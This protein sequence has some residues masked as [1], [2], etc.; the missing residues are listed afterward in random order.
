MDRSD[1]RGL[2]LVL[3]GSCVPGMW[4]PV[5]RDLRVVAIATLFSAKNMQIGAPL[6]IQLAL[7]FL[8]LHSLRWNGN[9]VLR[10]IAGIVWVLHALFLLHSGWAVRDVRWHTGTG[11]VLLA[12]SAIMRR[13][14]SAS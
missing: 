7:V 4:R 14:S 8:L 2:S 6:A 3:G 1:C 5:W 10:L 9:G 12:D 13:S 11:E